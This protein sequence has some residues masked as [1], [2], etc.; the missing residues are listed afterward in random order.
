MRLSRHR[1]LSRVWGQFVRTSDSKRDRRATGRR[2]FRS[3]S[4]FGEHL[5]QRLVLSDW[6]GDLL[7]S[8]LNAIGV[9]TGPV[10]VQNSSS[11]TSSSSGQTSQLR[12]DVQALQTELASLA[13]KSGVTVADLTSLAADSQAIAQAGARIDVKSL[14]SSVNE[15]AT[16]IA[17]GTSTTQA[18]T[19]FAAV[20]ASTSVSQATITQAFTDLSKAITDSG[21]NSTDL[22]TVA[23]DQAAIQTDLSSLPWGGFFAGNGVFGDGFEGGPFGGV[24]EGPA[25]GSLAAALSSI[26][27]ETGTV[28]TVSAS[29]HG[30][31]GGDGGQTSQFRT[32]IQALQTELASL[33]SKSGV[34]VADLTSLAADS[35]AIAQAGA[36][37]DVK[38]LDSAVNELATAIA[39]GTSTTQAQTDFAA[40]FASTSVS[41]ATITQAFTDLSKAITDSGV[42]STD[43]ATVAKDQA[44]IQSDLSNLGSGGGHSGEVPA[45][46]RAAIAAAARRAA[47]ADRRPAGSSTGGTSTGSTS[48]GS[49]S[50][51]NGGTTSTGTTTPPLPTASPT[52]ASDPATTSLANSTSSATPRARRARRRF[53]GS[54]HSDHDGDRSSEGPSLFVS[55]APRDEDPCSAETRRS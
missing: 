4:M 38:S 24:F 14:D 5:E 7:G 11:S 21:V 29:V 25:G 47:E 34:T 31:W 54:D 32:D 37:I 52:V 27:V 35:Q 42:T 43:L 8:A 55:E 16:A 40:V 51:G 3:G 19:D 48:S 50:S 45:R 1:I 28:T 17:A 9:V 33:A 10:V 22:T 49:T 39:G 26:G 44:A 53:V 20:F 36:R 46:C 23:T 18:Q 15:L 30:P 6:G 13:A 41:Q 12:T 2:R